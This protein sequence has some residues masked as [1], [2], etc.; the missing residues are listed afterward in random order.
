MPV[1]L[2]ASAALPLAV[3]SPPV[4]LDASANAP[5]AVLFEPVV[6]FFGGDYTQGFP[7]ARRRVSLNDCASAIIY[8]RRRKVFLEA[9]WFAAASHWISYRVVADVG[10]TAMDY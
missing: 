1:V 8:S 3:F 10:R 4:V 2:E 5:V 7:Y 9:H 6:A